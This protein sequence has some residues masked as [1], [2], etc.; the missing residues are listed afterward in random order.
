MG[1]SPDGRH[2]LINSYPVVSRSGMRYDGSVNTWLNDLEIYVMN[3]DG[4]GVVRLTDNS[5]SDYP[6]AWSP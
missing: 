6:V 2:I 5:V 3:A 4:T 1:W